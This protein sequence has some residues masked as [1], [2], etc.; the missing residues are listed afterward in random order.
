[1][2]MHLHH[3]KKELMKALMFDEKVSTIVHQFDHLIPLLKPKHFEE[4]FMEMNTAHDN[5]VTVDEFISFASGLT[6]KETLTKIFVIID[7]EKTGK[8]DKT[9]C[10]SNLSSNEDILKL[11]QQYDRLKYLKDT[12]AYE[13]QFLRTETNDPDKLTL[14]EFNDIVDSVVNSID[15][16]FTPMYQNNGSDN[17]Q[18]TV[19][20]TNGD[21]DNNF[22]T[23]TTTTGNDNE[24]KDSKKIESEQKK[25]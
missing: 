1:M 3:R 10:L 16:S 13:N 2:R 24:E 20:S 4:A 17:V 12:D 15:S 18:I 6:M 21:Y 22:A 11:I 23:T 25:I 5:H 19:T 8:I 9:E 14:D 7:K